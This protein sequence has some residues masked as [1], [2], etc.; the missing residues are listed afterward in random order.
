MQRPVTEYIPGIQSSAY[1]R[2]IAIDKVDVKGLRHPINVRDR[3]GGV[4]HTVAMFNM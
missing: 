4:Q 2:Q 3:T 1:S